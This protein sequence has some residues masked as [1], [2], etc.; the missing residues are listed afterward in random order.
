MKS[1]WTFMIIFMTFTLVLGMSWYVEYDRASRI[2]LKWLQAGFD[3]NNG[4]LYVD[5]WDFEIYDVLQH[6]E[7]DFQMSQRCRILSIRCL[8]RLH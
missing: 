6:F 4:S 1:W 5:E 3:V 2:R 7:A 8:D